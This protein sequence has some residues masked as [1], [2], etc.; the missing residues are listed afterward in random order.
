MR[1]LA[2]L[3]ALTTPA[4]QATCLFAKDTPPAGWYEWAAVLVAGDVTQVESRGRIDVV[5]LEVTETFR[6]PANVKT[7]TLEVPNNL[8]GVCKIARP[9]IGEHVLGAL[10]ANSD[11]LAVPLSDAYAERLRAARGK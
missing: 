8:W 4:A 6:G 2:L 5:S 7:A 10:N 9:A 3:L 11:A 1:L